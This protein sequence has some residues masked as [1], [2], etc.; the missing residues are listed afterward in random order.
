DVLDLNKAGL[1]QALAQPAHALRERVR[2]CGVE[3][4]DH[5]H[6]RLL[7]PRRERQRRRAAEQRDELAAPHSITSS[8]S[9]STLSEN[10]TPSAFAVLRLITNSNLLDCMT[11]KSAGVAPLRILPA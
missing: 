1:L 9:D 8:A 7:R 3:K 6:R 11:G 2:R 5:R 10:L 4:P